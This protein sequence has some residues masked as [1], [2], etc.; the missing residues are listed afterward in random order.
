[1]CIT[2]FFLEVMHYIT[3]TCNAKL[4]HYTL[5]PHS[6][7]LTS[8]IVYVGDL[9][10]SNYLMWEILRDELF[11]TKI[12]RLKQTKFTV[13][14]LLLLLSNITSNHFGRTIQLVLLI[15]EQSHLVR[16]HNTTSFDFALH[17]IKN[18][19]CHCSTQISYLS[20]FFLT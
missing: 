16:T 1:M 20:G 2:V 3:I 11:H 9:P 6:Y 14:L 18:K 5:H 7:L 8:E 17:I 10:H 4:A 12:F 13:Q 15:L 19:V